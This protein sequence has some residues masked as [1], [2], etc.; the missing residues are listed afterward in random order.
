MYLSSISLNPDSKLNIR[1]F[2]ELLPDP[3]ID[4][5]RTDFP[6]DGKCGLFELDTGNITYHQEKKNLPSLIIGVSLYN[7]EP[8]ELRRVLVSLADQVDE[9]REIVSCNV[10][11]VSDGYSQ[12]NPRTRMY[13]SALFCN[14]KTEECIF[15]AL[16]SSLNEYCKEK[17]LADEDERIGTPVETR[18][19]QPPPLTYVVQRVKDGYRQNIRVRGGKDGNDN[20]FLK[21]TLI[22][23]SL[24]RRKH[25]SQSWMFNFAETHQS[26]S[27]EGNP[28]ELDKGVSSEGNPIELDK[29]VSSEGNP[30][31][32]DKGVSSQTKRDKLLFLTDCGTLFEKGCLVR[33]VAYMRENKLCV[34]CTGRQRVMTSEEQDCEDEGIIEKFFRLVQMAD[35]EGSYATYTGAFS[36]I[37]CLPVLPGPCVMVRFSALHKS[38]S[39]R[40][41]D[42]LE[43]V[44]LGKRSI[45]P[46]PLLEPTNDSE[47]VTPRGGTEY[48]QINLYEPYDGSSNP[49]EPSEISDSYDVD[50]NY[51]N[52]PLSEAV[53]TRETVLEHFDKLVGT[54][55]GETNMTIENVKL[56]EDR[57]PSY[58]LVTHGEKGAY[59]TWVDGAVFKFQAETSFESFVKQRRRWL[60]G[61]MFCYIWT[62]FIRPDLFLKSSHNIFR[63]YAIWSMF[64]V[65]LLTYFL[66]SISPSIFTSGLYLGLISLLGNDNQTPII[67]ATVL[68]SVYTYAFIWVHRYKSFIKP[69]FYLTAF[70]NMFAMIFIVAGFIRQS[71][72]WAFSPT[73]INRIIIQWS[74][75]F[76]M[77]SPFV[78]ALIALDFKSFFLLLKSCIPYW[79][80]LPTMIGSFMLYSIA[81]VFDVTW[82]N[83]S[84]S[85]GANFKSATQ[86]Q[87]LDLEND[88]SSNSLVGLI[89]MT[90]L[91]IVIEAIVIYFGVNS[92]FIVG[93]LAIIFSTTVLQI[94]ISFI[95]FLV[96]HLSGSTFWQKCSCCL[97]CGRRANYL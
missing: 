2:H 16:M 8:E 59:T 68:F 50:A 87:L 66:A 47:I 36:L 69:L 40:F 91:N 89:F 90:V 76:I 96:K 13:L 26:F 31:E 15:G 3:K 64:F 83:R 88:F 24:N 61:A 67:V 32:L 75:I 55:P 56:A 37:G 6:T 49:S 18:K 1:G 20:R 53:P 80:F 57:I 43:D 14:N 60:N 73:G 65:Q 74:T 46:E 52:I 93:C 85:A 58:S 92:W 39:F 34:G 63:R 19:K 81:R 7:E 23:K 29:G 71:S 42:P 5:F 22:L 28:I 12:M 44:I 45:V 9:M 30:T 79:L 27:S 82:G 38:R 77:A 62:V 35:Y 21:A 84:G 97:C 95:Y 54:G 17:A 48:E 4:Y 72:A 33:L 10:V 11:I 25:N 41:K 86:K 78:M 51:V 94:V 70:V